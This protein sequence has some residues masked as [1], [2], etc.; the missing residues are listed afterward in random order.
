MNKYR[1]HIKPKNKYREFLKVLNGNLHLTERE[2]DIF[3]VMM[4]IDEEWEPVEEG[5][6][7]H[8]ISTSNRKRI[9]KETLVNK[10]NLTKYVRLFRSKGLLISNSNGGVEVTPMFMPSIKGET[11]KIVFMLDWSAK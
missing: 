10:N 2:L 9:M 7:K 4:K 5:G 3:S 1:K 6:F 8:I 11:I